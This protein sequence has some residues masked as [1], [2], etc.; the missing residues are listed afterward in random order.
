[1]KKKARK[2]GIGIVSVLTL[3]FIALK[4][5]GVFTW[6]WLW[7]LSPIWITGVLMVLIVG[8]VLV[9]GRIKKGKW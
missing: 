9:A 2:G 8:V 1:M 3:T 6:P 7:V 5:L 4:L